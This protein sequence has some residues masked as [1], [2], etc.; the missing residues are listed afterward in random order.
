MLRLGKQNSGECRVGH[1]IYERIWEG[2]LQEKRPGKSMEGNSS[3]TKDEL[4]Q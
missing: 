2:F 4:S 1:L 3:S